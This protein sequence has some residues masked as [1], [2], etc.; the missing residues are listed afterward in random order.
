MNGHLG[1]PTGAERISDSCVPVDHS[2][3]CAFS[4]DCFCSP[5]T[6]AYKE[7]V[8]QIQQIHEFIAPERARRLANVDIGVGQGLSKISETGEQRVNP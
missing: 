7:G 4:A 6:V 5:Q 3:A 8:S 2:A 1:G